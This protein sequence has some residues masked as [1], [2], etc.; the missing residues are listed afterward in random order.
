MKSSSELHEHFYFIVEDSFFYYLE[1]T[2]LKHLELD[3]KLQ[4]ILAH[5]C[6]TDG[7]LKQQFFFFF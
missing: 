3:L 2:D 6:S 5:A 1:N 4:I 7:N